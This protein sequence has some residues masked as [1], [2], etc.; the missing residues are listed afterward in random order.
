MPQ[1]VLFL[2]ENPADFATVGPDEMQR[3]IER[4]AAWSEAL[5]ARGAMRDGHKLR[6]EGGRHL[7][8]GGSGLGVS[9]GPYGEAKEVVSGFFVIEA[10][11]Y[12]EAV[13]IAGGCP[14]LD[15]GWVEVREIEPI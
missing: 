14:H 13:E 9:D 10:G 1:Y 11:S 2:H 7:R 6:D 4:Y 12:D 15:F 5:A 3:I 8:R